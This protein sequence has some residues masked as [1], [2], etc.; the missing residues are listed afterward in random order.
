MAKLLQWAVRN[1]DGA[2]AL[3]LALGVATLGLLNVVNQFLVESATLLILAVLAE[4]VMRERWRR[5]QVEREI[6]D[7]LVENMAVLKALRGPLDNLGQSGQLVTEARAALARLSMVQ[8]LNNTDVREALTTAWADTD[9][10]HFK[11]GTGA[12]LRKA[13]LPE[14]LENSRRRKSR[15]HVRLEIVDPTDEAAC[16]RYAESHNTL[17]SEGLDDLGNRWSEES[18]RKA[19]FA[20][21]LAV[22]WFKQR[23]GLLDTDLRLS[24]VT[25]TFRWDMS[26]R[27]IMI[28]EG[29]PTAP[30][31][32]VEK[33]TFYYDRWST[34]LT[35]SLEQA[36]P[37]PL[38]ADQLLPLSDRPT[39]NETRRLLESIRTPLPRSFT[40]RDVM[41]VVRLAFERR[42]TY[43]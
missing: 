18:V 36:R 14:C 10:W 2:V 3:V 39:V 16:R 34:E 28:T 11:G 27:W 42:S 24:S 22:C 15:L 20:T 33:G 41:D 23:Y 4:V 1:V 17:W 6:R 5:T 13:T 35:V 8:V 40:D 7:G 38:D 26:S 21:I 31:L 37:V 29:D 12:Y 25:T 30:A 19:S 43:P 9:R 32:L